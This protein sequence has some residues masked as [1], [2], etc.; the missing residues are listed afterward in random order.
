MQYGLLGW[1]LILSHKIV[2]AQDLKKFKAYS[3]V[4][5]HFRESLPPKF[6]DFIK[7]G[8]TVMFPLPRIEIV[9]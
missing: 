6:E 3:L 5:W 1:I 4:P 2:E 7:E 9:A 8:G